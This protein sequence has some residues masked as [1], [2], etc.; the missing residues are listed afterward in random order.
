MRSLGLAARFVSGYIYSPAADRLG[1]RRLG[2]GHTHAWVRV[3]LPSD[4]WVD[5]DPTKGLVG[6]DALVRVA[7][8]RDPR[9]AL[10]L[11]GTFEGE[12]AD[13]LG[14]DVSVDVAIESDY[15]MR[16]NRLLALAG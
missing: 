9:Q 8:V 11:C 15:E 13:Y 14:M 10:P 1:E 6:A 4:G 12:S 16:N 3:Y 2:G 5:F 7:V